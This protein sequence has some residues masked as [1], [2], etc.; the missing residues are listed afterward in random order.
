[1]TALK[2]AL[3]TTN[4]VAQLPTNAAPTTNASISLS[5]ALFDAR[6]VPS[7]SELSFRPL[8]KHIVRNVAPHYDARSCFILQTVEE[9]TADDG[10]TANSANRFIC[11]INT[12]WMVVLEQADTG[13]ALE[14]QPP[15]SAARRK[16]RTFTPAS[17]RH[18]H[19]NALSNPRALRV[20]TTVSG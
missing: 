8:N 6:L 7:D 2:T 16:L 11:S 13:D 5:L 10:L 3:C 17:N 15:Q 18:D 20:C 14:S 19:R 12:G 1:M 9:L 4:A